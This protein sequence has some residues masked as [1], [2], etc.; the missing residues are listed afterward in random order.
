MYSSNTRTDI[1]KWNRIESSQINAYFTNNWFWQG[2][3]DNSMK[4]EYSCQQMVLGILDIH[5][6]KNETEFLTA[7]HMQKL[8]QNE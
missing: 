4:K 3:Q 5:M 8:I 1:E 6:L 2:Y 7:H